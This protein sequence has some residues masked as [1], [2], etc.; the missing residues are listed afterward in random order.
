MFLTDEEIRKAI[1][2]GDASSIK[3]YIIEPNIKRIDKALGQENDPMFLA[4]AV[5]YAINL[6]KSKKD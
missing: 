1:R 3:R 5:E 6:A 2:L 4:Y